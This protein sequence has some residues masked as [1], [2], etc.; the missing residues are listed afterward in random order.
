[1]WIL[2]PLFPL[3][4]LRNHDKTV[5]TFS[6]GFPMTNIRKVPVCRLI[7]TRNLEKLTASNRKID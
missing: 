5:A 1:M 7:S 4:L 3:L 2:I 6:C